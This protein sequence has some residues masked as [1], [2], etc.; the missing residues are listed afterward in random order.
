MKFMI[1][2]LFV[3]MVLIVVGIVFVFVVEKWDM[4]MVYLVFNFYFVMG[5]EFV[6]CVI[7]GIGGE[8]EIVIYLF[9][10][11]FFGVQIKCVI[12]IGQV[13]IGECLLFGYQNENVLFG[14]DFILFLVMFF[15][16][17]DKFWKVVKLIIEKVLVDQNLMLF[18]VVL[19]LLQGLYFKNEVNFVVDMKGIKFCSYNNVM[20]CLVE[21][22]GML[23]VIIEV[24]EISQVFVIGVVDFMV[25]F[26]FIGYDCKVWELLNYFYEVDVWLLCNYVMVNFGVWDGVFDQNKNV[27]CGCVELVE[28]VG[29]WCFKEYIGFMLQGLCD[30]GMIVGLV[31]DQMVG[32]LKEIGVIMINEWLEV[33]GEDGVVIVEFFK[34]MQ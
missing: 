7:I 5:V 17:S 13:L 8:I 28:Y 2:V 23:L 3:V 4:L 32:E 27:I 6:K 22:I 18:Y 16:D 29:N 24:V 34:L 15:D 33:V 14:F 30:G 25:F 26:G 9:G 19:W 1:K 31:F 10:L 20:F 11:L 12:Q 21:L